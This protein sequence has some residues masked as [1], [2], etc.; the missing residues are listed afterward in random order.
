MKTG[1]KNT[2]AIIVGN[3]KTDFQHTLKEVKTAIKGANVKKGVRSLRSTKEGKLLITLEKDEQNAEKI[4]QILKNTEQLKEYNI[5]RIGGKK[6][7]TIYI[8][9][10]DAQAKKQDVIK[11]IR[12]YIPELEEK[13]IALSELRPMANQMQA[14][15]MNINKEAAMKLLKNKYIMIDYVRCSLE[16][17]IDL[18]RCHKCWK[19]DHRATECTTPDLV[20]TCFKC[21]KK[22]HNRS[23]C[24]NEDFCPLCKTSGHRAGTSRCPVFKRSLSV[25]RRATKRQNVAIRQ[26]SERWKDEI[27]GQKETELKESDRNTTPSYTREIVDPHVSCDNISEI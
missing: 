7:E 8:R 6:L 5:A 17:K 14:A 3:D 10:M 27:G 12:E 11:G 26:G 25:A 9:G 22:G 20:D 23:G 2:Y 4:K 19:Y 1:K 21:G 18:P 13:E 15:T 24:I 16:K